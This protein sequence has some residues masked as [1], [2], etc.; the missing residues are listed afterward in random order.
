MNKSQRLKESQREYADILMQM[1]NIKDETIQ[2]IITKPPIVE[3]MS[4]SSFLQH[5][6][7]YLALLNE[8]WGECYR[9]LKKDGTLWIFCNN[10]FYNE[11]LIPV[12]F[13]IANN[14]QL[15]GFNLRNIIIW[16][17]LDA[18]Q[19]SG[20]LLNRYSSILFFSK[21]KDYKFDIDKIREPHIWKDYEWGGGRRSRYN[22]KGKNPSNFWLKIESKKG[23]ILREI[24]L[25]F[26][27]C[28]QRCIIASTE[29]GDT[30][31][32]V[33][34]E[35]SSISEIAKKMGRIPVCCYSKINYKRE[36]SQP[37][38]G[39]LKIRPQKEEIDKNV[40]TGKIYFKTSEEMPEIPDS[41]IQVIITSPPYWG[42]RD[43]NVKDQIGFDESYD[44]YLQRLEKVWRECYRV[45]KP[46]GSL[47]ININKRIIDG[48]M[49]LFPRDIIKSACRIGFHLK[50]IVIWHKPISVPT[51]GPK[52]FTDRYEYI[53]FFTKDKKDYLFKPNELKQNDY[54]LPIQDTRYSNVWKMFR[55]IGNIGK[56]IN[57]MINKRKIK[58]TAIYPKELVKR[59]ILLCSN[60][61]DIV[62]DPFTGSGTTIVVA[63]ALGRRWIGYELNKDYEAIIRYRLKNEGYSLAPWIND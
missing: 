5:Y 26:E 7:R 9:V 53:L 59:I 50:D 33:F 21:K 31:L 1:R 58:H 42:L 36:V 8:I 47:W 56:E 54:L 3:R 12:T 2:C 24:P 6:E 48:K 55:K 13:E 39:R 23:K 41:S 45:L 27:E 17:N 61:G 15:S 51:T 35:N 40:A 30:I 25:T 38:R 28:V 52:N 62:L 11:E 20:D 22:P 34:A 19:F 46:T 57:V 44:I 37:K 29:K 32:D 63:N 60:K 43:Y 14:V 4:T 16:Y 10:Y 18:E 49:L